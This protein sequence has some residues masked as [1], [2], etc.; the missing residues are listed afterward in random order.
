VLFE[1]GEMGLGSRGASFITGGLVPV[2]TWFKKRRVM[3]IEREAV[4]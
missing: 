3:T 4:F 2:L 1:I